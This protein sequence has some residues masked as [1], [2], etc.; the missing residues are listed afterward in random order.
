[1]NMPEKSFVTYNTHL[2]AGYKIYLYILSLSGS[3]KRSPDWYKPI[4]MK[5]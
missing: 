4:R 1:M 3:R 2:H 5:S